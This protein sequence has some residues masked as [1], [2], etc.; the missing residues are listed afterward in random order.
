MWLRSFERFF[1]VGPSPSP[2]ARPAPSR[3]AT[4]RRSCGSSTTR[5]CA[6]SSSASSILTEEQVDLTRFDRY[7]ESSLAV[8][9]GARPLHREARPP[10][11][12]GD[13]PHPAPRVVRGPAPAAPRP[14]EAVAPA[15]R[16]LPGGG[17]DPLPR[18]AAQR[19]R[20]PAHRQEVQ[21][22]PR[23]H[24]QP[25]GEPDHPRRSPT[26]PSGGRRPR[27][28]SSSSACCTTSSTPTPRGCPRRQLRDTILLFSLVV[29]ETRL[30]LSY[31]EK[32]VLQGPRHRAARSTRSTTRSCTAS[33]SSSR[34]SSTRSS[35]T[36]R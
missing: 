1:R 33:P 16:D 3:C 29:S 23:P 34:R 5:S 4:G 24:P 17:Q 25:A 36:S 8:E 7:V 28:S 12:P 6:S 31:V 10:H 22:R 26:R 27:C 9:E 2:T 35:P 15:V 13:G 32:R 30:L 11:D 14:R 18:G 19:P 20:G 21:A